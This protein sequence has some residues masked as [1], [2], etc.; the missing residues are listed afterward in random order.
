MDKKLDTQIQN[1]I[2]HPNHYCQGDIECI[3]AM[4]SAFGE[5]E[6][7]IYCKINAFKYIWRN[8][9]KGK[10]REDTEKALWYLNKRSNLLKKIED[11][12]QK[13]NE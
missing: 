13:I 1:N 9:L 12:E 3:D 7:A 5:K 11:D 10:P 2:N 8:E 4:I 6:V